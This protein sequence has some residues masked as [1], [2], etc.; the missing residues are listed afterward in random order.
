MITHSQPIALPNTSQSN[1]VDNSRNLSTNASGS[2]SQQQPHTNSMSTSTNTS[3]GLNHI[4][5]ARSNLSSGRNGA[6]YAMQ[7]AGSYTGSEGTFNP[8]SFTRHFL[9]S[10]ISWRAASWGMP[11]SIGNGGNRWNGH[12]ASPSQALFGSIE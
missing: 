12:T 10:P 7:D 9:G 11:S 1:H 5:I 2:S 4:A 3:T 6:D 8:A